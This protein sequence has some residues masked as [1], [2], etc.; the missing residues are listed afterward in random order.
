MKR[1]AIR[2]ILPAAAAAGLVAVLTRAGGS[3]LPDREGNPIGGKVVKTDAEWRAQLTPEQYRV[4]R[5]AD[6]EQPFTGEY[7]DSH[8]DGMYVCVCCGQP[9][10]D[11]REKF[12]SH[13][14]WPSFWDPRDNA[15]ITL[16]TD[17]SHG[18]ART[19]VL[20]SR[21]EAHLGHVFDDGP[22]P[23]GLRFCINSA[24]LLLIPREAHK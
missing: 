7:W 3:H 4:T 2:F 8:A 17:R 14:G 18:M 9:L 15:A 20:C 12:D 10:F 13:C 21:C 16:R 24:S 22:P 5:R 6:T 11:S 23:T 1:S 19:E